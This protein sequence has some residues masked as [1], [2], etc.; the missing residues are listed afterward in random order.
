MN[1][2]QRKILVIDED[3]QMVEALRLTCEEAGYTVVAALDGAEGLRAAY[4]EHPDLVLFGTMMPNRDA[5]QVL[6]TLRL[7]SDIPIIVMTAA[8]QDARC[9]RARDTRATDFLVKGVHP[10]ELLTHID[11]RIRQGQQW[12]MR[13]PQHIGNQLTVDLYERVVCLENKPVHLTPTEWKVLAYLVEHKG[14]VATYAELARA[15]WGETN[16][17]EGRALKAVVSR[18]RQKLDDHTKPA[19]LIHHVRA[20]GYSLEP[21]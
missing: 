10:Q 21:R 14:R 16:Y 7:V 3:P 9:I 18:L 1:S 4:A 11:T 15:G 13:E 20:E 19:R 12:N 8:S 5:F 6:D 2:A 17:H